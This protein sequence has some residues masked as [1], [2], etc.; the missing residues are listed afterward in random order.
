M[1]PILASSLPAKRFIDPDSYNQSFHD[2]AVQHAALTL[3]NDS[4]YTLGQSLGTIGWRIRK[5]YFKATPKTA[6]SGSSAHTS[7]SAGASST[8][9]SILTKS[10][11]QSHSKLASA[12]SLSLESQPKCLEGIEFPILTWTEY[13]PDKYVDDKEIGGALKSLA[14]I[15]HPFIMPIDFVATNEYGALFVRSFYTKG[16]LKDLLYGTTPKNP[17]MQ[18]YGN[19]ATRGRGLSVKDIATYGRQILE[20]LHFLHSKGLPFGEYE[21]TAATNAFASQLS[22]QRTSLFFLI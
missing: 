9:K 5:H 20:A 16:S 8:G 2:L 15:Q 3:R 7:G 6:S 19:S 11:S 21:L 4:V 1:N 12:T 10:G 18:K 17:Y 13:G 14:T 22:T